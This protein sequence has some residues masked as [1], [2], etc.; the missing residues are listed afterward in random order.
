M[1]PP[2]LRGPR[3]LRAPLDA[4]SKKRGGNRV[5]DSKEKNATTEL[6][7]L[8][9]RMRFG[10]AEEVGHG[11]EIDGLGIL[12]RTGSVR[13]LMADQRT[14]AKLGKAMQARLNSSS[15][16]KRSLNK[17]SSCGL[18]NSLAFTPVQGIELIDPGLNN[19]AR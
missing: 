15:E 11:D 13:A 14:K 1:T 16:L 19:A 6:Q 5:R 7:K 12:T 9:N 3:A 10:K 18:Q 2:Q 4:P 17:D 8:Q